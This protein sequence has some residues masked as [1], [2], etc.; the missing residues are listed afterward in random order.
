MYKENQQKQQNLICF[1][2][3]EREKKSQP[4]LVPSK[5]FDLWAPQPLCPHL[6]LLAEAQLHCLQT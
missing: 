6:F 3:K 2:E 4:N 1:T 5:N